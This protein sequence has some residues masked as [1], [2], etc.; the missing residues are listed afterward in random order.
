MNIARELG[1]LG[2]EHVSLT[3]GEPTLHPKIIDIVKLLSDYGVHTTLITN[4]IVSRSKLA[5]LCDLVSHTII[6][7]D[8]AKKET[9]ESIR[10]V[11]TWERVLSTI[12]FLSSEGYEFTVVMALSRLNW[13]EAPAFI[14]LCVELGASSSA[15]IP[16]MPVGRAST[17]LTL[18]PQEVETLIKQVDEVASEE[19]FT[20]ELWCMPFA[21]ALIRS[22]YVVVSRCRSF[23]LMDIDPGG[24][25]L[26]CDTID[27]VVTTVRKGVY[28]A[29]LE[30][31]S[32]EVVRRVVY[33]KLNP[34]CTECYCNYI[35]KGGCFARSYLRTGQLDGPDPLCPLANRALT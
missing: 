8:G 15:F 6:S 4:G 35:C 27:I 24:R 13:K 3:G 28:N 16:V 26:L 7:L 34:P 32:S 5:K 25:V 18:T 23:S 33:P 31:C 19:K 29:W 12:D 9:H 14:K 11:G 20:V 1:Q 30:Y 22:P 10:G 17:E 2:V 21:I